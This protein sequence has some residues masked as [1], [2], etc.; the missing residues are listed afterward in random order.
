MGSDMAVSLSGC[1]LDFRGNI[2]AVACCIPGFPNG[3]RMLCE[4]AV[5]DSGPARSAIDGIL[6]PW[7]GVR[8][9]CAVP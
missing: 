9:T 3:E 6:G 8:R 7:S 2:R 4:I 1:G 5:R